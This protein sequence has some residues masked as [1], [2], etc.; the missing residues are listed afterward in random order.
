M[1]AREFEARY[2]EK[3][4][5]DVLYNDPSD[6]KRC[7]STGFVWAKIEGISAWCYCRCNDG[8]NKQKCEQ[9]ALPVYDYEMESLFKLNTFPHKAFIPSSFQSFKQG[10]DNKMSAFKK[11]LR[12]SEMFWQNCSKTS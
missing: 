9:Y 12:E 1:D 3:A 5:P 8:K 2:K 10:L 11:S 6:C 7:W 4:I